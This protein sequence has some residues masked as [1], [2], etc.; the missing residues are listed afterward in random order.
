MKFSRLRLLGFKSF[1]E[2]TDFVIEDGLTGVVGP[3]GCGKSNL[4]EAMR[5]VMGESSYKA[6]RASGMDDVIFAGSHNRPARNTAEVSLFLEK[7]GGRVPSGLPDADVIEVTRRIER[8]AGSVYKMN[9]KDVRARD[10]QLLFADASTGARSPAMV[11]QGQI[12]ELIAAKPTSRRAILEEAAGISGLHTRRHEAELRLRAAEQNLERLEDLLGELATQLDGLKRQARQATRYRTLSAEI[13]KSE[14]MILF[15]RWTDAR[16]AVADAE[17]SLAVEVKRVTE[18]GAVQAGTAKDQAVAAHKLASLRDEAAAATAAAQRIRLALAELDAEDGRIKDRIADLRRRLADFAADAGREERLI[19]DNREAL[20]RLA[21][22]EAALAGEES[23]AR[24][25]AAGADADLQKAEA[26]LATSEEALSDLTQQQAQLT[27]RRGQLE[28]TVRD[29]RSRVERLLGQVADIERDLAALSEKLSEETGVAQKE[30][31]VIAA[32]TQRAEAEAR[33]DEAEAAVAAARE[34]EAAARQ[35]VSEAEKHLNAIDAETGALSRV[36]AQGAAGPW[37]PIVEALKVKAGYEKAL[38]AAL[39]SDLEVSDDAG[40][41]IRWAMPG[42]A[43]ADASLP[44]GATPLG[45]HVKAPALLARR[46]AQI[47]LVVDDEMGER[48]FPALKPGQLLVTREG[49]MWRWDGLVAVADAPSAAAE[50]LAQKNRLDDLA[51]ERE[52]AERTLRRVSHDHEEIRAGLHSAAEAERTARDMLKTAHRAEAEARGALQRAEKAMGELIARRS[53]LEEARVRLSSSLEEARTA[54]REASESLGEMPAAD[55]VETRIGALRVKVGEDRAALAEART[56]VNG[57]AREADLRQAR[58]EAIAAERQSWRKRAESA[59]Q[60]VAVLRQRRAEAEHELASILAA[61]EAIGEKRKALFREAEA[62]EE[63]QKGAGDALAEGER[64]QATVDRAASD[65]LAELSARREARAR[66][67]ERLGAA[68]EKVD[69]T[70]KRIEESLDCSAAEVGAL[71]GLDP[72]AT[73]PDPA[74]VETRLE[75]LRLERERL[76]AVNL[77]AD[78]EAAEIAERR[79]A[80]IAERDDLVEA[81]KRLRQG[82]YSLNREARERLLDAFDRVNAHF[83]DLF[84]HLFGGGTAELQLVDSDDPLDAGLEI[85]ARPPGKKP[86]TMTL[87]S[88]GEQA[89]TAMALIF[90]VFLTNPAPICVLDE[91]DAPL[92]DANVERYCNLLEEMASRTDTRFVVVTHNP[93]TMARMNRLFGVTMSERGVSQLVSVDL[94]TAER[95]LEVG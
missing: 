88:G 43:S 22:E 6:M 78:E 80:L 19:A 61:P 35:P 82:I 85:I 62:A 37:T 71:A 29:A 65:A 93:I 47:G 20:D 67:E 69:D 31:A 38:G 83:Q 66:A 94:A 63:R 87:L 48:L 90:A 23:A 75:R 28:R 89:L 86:Q 40:A 25:R 84:A 92:D 64:H 9:G 79:D 55:G 77:R 60:Q 91:V 54:E 53:A 18:Q 5:W 42:E 68:R 59:E 73:P 17:E 13:R 4:V 24:G 7:A 76:G 57:L 15:I 3:N 49:R 45:T 58:L 8:E 39:G 50:R 11:R 52:E 1:V 95:F 10:V 81:I 27:A 2:P 32:E 14:A 74:A 26:R 46:L 16:K 36:L 51:A 30:A 44:A 34:A 56:R 12:G 72:A 41:P 21:S 70:V 33:A